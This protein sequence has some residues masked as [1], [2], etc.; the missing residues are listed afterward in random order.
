MKKY[1]IS[2]MTW[3][4]VEEAKADK[5]VILIPNASME[6][7]GPQTP[8]GD[9]RATEIVANRIA[10]KTNC[11]VAPTLPFGY[12]D[13]YRGFPG[14]IS[15]EAST[16]EAVLYDIARSFLE[17]DF[18]HLVFLCG[19]NGNMSIIEHV[20]RKICRQWEIRPATLELWRLFSTNYFEEVYGQPNPPIGHGGDPMTSISLYLYP[21]DV[22]LDLIE[23]NGYKKFQGLDIKGFSAINVNDVQ[24]HIYVDMKDISDNGVLGDATIASKEVGQKL[25]QRVVD[26]GIEFVNI[27]EQVNTST[28]DVYQK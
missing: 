1:R 25:I 6:E 22:R 5:P 27:F 19:H 12:S 23:K 20:A 10:E 24:G 2:H 13:V 7:H 3:K 28:T 9:Y 14:C 18:D 16:V 4:E 11:L 21:I 26:I 15:L 8:M 17:H